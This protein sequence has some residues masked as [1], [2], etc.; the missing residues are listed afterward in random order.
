MSM[1]SAASMSD[2]ERSIASREL[3]AR[4]YRDLHR[5]AERE[6]RR[7]PGEIVSP[8][9]LIHETFLNLWR[10]KF[11][12]E[13]HLLAYASHAMRGL[14]VSQLRNR[15]RRKRGGGYDIRSLSMDL[16]QAFDTDHSLDALADAL[17]SLAKLDSRLAECVD[18]K[19]FCG[20]SFSEI[21]CMWNV[22]ERTVQ[23]DWEKARVLLNTLLQGVQG[24]L[25]AAT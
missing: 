1:D 14:I 17:E 6:L 15:G 18:L 5:M 7:T 25:H 24:E 8:T 16:P 23:R 19:F 21:A 11:V 10:R 4:V 9:T 12:D 20:F 2:Q 22:S 3:F 13:A